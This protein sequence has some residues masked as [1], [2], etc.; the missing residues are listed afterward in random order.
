M[1]SGCAVNRYGWLYDIVVGVLVTLSV[2]IAMEAG[3]LGVGV[4]P[5]VKMLWNC[6][7]MEVARREM[8]IVPKVDMCSSWRPT[9]QEMRVV[10]ME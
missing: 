9:V 6:S 7:G 1:L 2:G 8:A 4:V 5:G 10:G 3:E